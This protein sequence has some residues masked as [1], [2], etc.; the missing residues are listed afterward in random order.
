[1][2]KFRRE[3]FDSPLHNI[4]EINLIQC[5]SFIAFLITAAVIGFPGVCRP[6]V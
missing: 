2:K 6:S 4:A 5:V 3:L 1:M